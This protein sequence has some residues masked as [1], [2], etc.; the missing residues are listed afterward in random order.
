MNQLS[1]SAA[2]IPVPTTGVDPRV[3]LATSVHAGPGLYAVLVGSGMSSA[4]GVRTGWQVVQDLIRKVAIAEGVNPDVVSEKPEEWWQK[5]GRPEPRYDTLLQALAETDGARR[6]LLHAYFERSAVDGKPVVPTAGHEALASLCASGRVRLIVTT[7]FDRLIE[8]A[9]E[10][11]GVTPQVISSPSA[12]AAMIPLV[13]APM[14]VVKLH[15]DYVTEGLRNTPEELTTYPEEWRKLLAQV[16]DDYGLLVVGW[17]GDY[18]KALAQLMRES[19]PRRYPVFWTVHDG[20]LSEEARR[21]I[22]LRQAT[23]IDIR[24]ASEF[25][26]DLRERLQRLDEVAARR[27][28]PTAM[29]TYHFPP[30][31]TTARPNGWAVLPLLS[32]RAVAALG[33]ATAESSGLIR[34][35]H[36][37]ELVQVLRMAAVTTRIRYLG[38]W[39]PASALA[40][41]LGPG[42]NVEA[43]MMAD[44]APT[45]GGHQSIDHAEY[46]LGGDAKAG[47][48][49]LVTV[50]FPGWGPQG[51]N[52]VFTL[53]VGISVARPLRLADAASLWRDGLV[54][55]S[56][57]LPRVFEDLM[58]A[59]T[60]VH[61]V[62]I[63]ALAASSDGIDRNRPNDLLSRIDMSPLG[64]PTRHL[65]EHVG[66]AF[67]V[68]GP[69]SEH[70]AGELVADGIDQIALANGYLDPRI[71]LSALGY[72]LGLPSSGTA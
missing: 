38:A 60:S 14:T 43:P 70:D 22:A 5:Q 44:W 16:F 65:S 10:R 19:V 56:A 68:S 37:D 31:L 41:P 11:A 29:R 4:A 6:L 2:A 15:G 7:N 17:S 53:D 72:E 27:Q 69:L 66:I 54:L 52:F 64:T 40:D 71:G 46:R 23:I 63:H 57:V 18:D 62:E 30:Q 28:R 20:S 26:G 21:L 59:D 13:H 9:L 67:R 48:S 12:V 8:R 32:L 61:Q 3:A 50:R 39:P 58:P 24:G 33:P 25:F 55:V 47:V 45:P 35:Q 49:T 42:A 51:G 1:R 36:R 34:P